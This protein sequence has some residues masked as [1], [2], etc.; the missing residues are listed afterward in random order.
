MSEIKINMD[1]LIPKEKNTNLIPL[2]IDTVVYDTSNK[3][4]GGALPHH[5]DNHDVD[6][7]S[8]GSSDGSVKVGTKKFKE[9]VIEEILR[10]T[11]LSE[12][13][14]TLVWKDRWDYISG[15]C[16]S[17]AEIL[18]IAQTIFSFTESAFKLGWI[19]FF[20]GLLGVICIALSR[21]GAFSSKKSSDNTNRSNE[22]L[23]SVNIKD[24]IP[25]LVDEKFDIDNAVHKKISQHDK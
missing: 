22:L 10:P 15:F 21:F 3:L 5:V 14:H 9:Q 18:G 2:E 16:F 1:S 24:R 8:S 25:D 6:E 7:K 23:H 19:A 13:R 11:F 4:E 20:G 17:M 12:L